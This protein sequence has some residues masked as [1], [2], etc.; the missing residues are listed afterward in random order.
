M[1]KKFHILFIGLVSLLIMQSCNNDVDI[2]ASYQDIVV[3]YGLLDSNEDTTFLKI[4]KAFLGPENALIM[5]K[6]P[7]SSEFVNKL[8][9]KIWPEDNPSQ[10]YTFDTI[11]INNKEEGLFYN[12][13]QQLY[14][15]PFKPEFNTKYMLQI[16]YKEMEITSEAQNIEEFTTSDISKPGFA[17]AIGF[18]YDLINP[19]TWYR[20]DQAPRYDVTIRF[21]Y[22]ELW[23]GQA[24][25][26]YRSFVWHTAT[27]K[28]TTGEEVES[29]YNGS[30]FFNA[31][32]LYVAY[33]DQ[34]T[35]DKVVS[36]YTGITEFIVAAAGI[37]LNTY[38]EVTEPSSSIIQDRP[39]YSNITNGEGIFSARVKAVKTKVLNDETKYRIK[40]DFHY[41]KFEY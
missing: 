4:N 19:V 38:M 9:V 23:E 10:V 13:Y 11:T 37:E 34:A 12:P 6:I 26:V 28:A 14:F 22:K 29:Y 24:D 25:T 39:Q 3:V 36:R 8:S 41:L 27:K 2:N 32:G 1:M 20:K 15:T 5:A 16:F 18:D 30:S 21:H 31:L 17:K 33:P 7:D 40:E 35:E